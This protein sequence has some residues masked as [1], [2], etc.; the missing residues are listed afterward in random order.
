M[1]IIVDSQNVVNSAE[2]APD[3]LRAE[4]GTYYSDAQ[5]VPGTPTQRQ[6][7]G[8]FASYRFR[9]KQSFIHEL[10]VQSQQLI[11]TKSSRVF[12]SGFKESFRDQ[13]Q[14][15]EFIESI[16]PLGGQNLDHQFYLD[17]VE[18]NNSFVK[19]Y[20]HPQ[21][22]DET[23]SFQSNQLINYNLVSYP[24]KEQK[25]NV[26][27]IADI[28]TPYD[29]ETYLVNNSSSLRDLMS[30]FRNRMTS[31][32]GNTSEIADK[33]RNIFRLT[34]GSLIS[35]EQYPYH[36][37]KRMTSFLATGQN[38]SIN[39][40]K[41]DLLMARYGK[42]K[43]L[44]QSIKTGLFSSQRQF[45]IGPG[46]V[47]ATIHN[48][49]GMMTSNRI[50]S[51]QEGADEL[52]LLPQNQIDDGTMQNRFVDQV[53]TVKF[54][55]EM[56]TFI[57][58]NSRTYEEIVK[59]NSSESF[60]VGYK[61]E[62]YLDNDATSP[63]QTYYTTKPR[64]YDTQ[65]KYGRKYIYK[66]KI[67][68]GVLGSSYVYSNL[69]IS[70]NSVAMETSGREL[71]GQLPAGYNDISSEEYRAYVDVEV[72]PSFQVVEYEVDVDEVAFMDTPTLPPQVEFFNQGHKASLE[73]FFS[74]IFARVESVTSQSP[75]EVI[76]EL[77]PLTEEE[78]RIANLVSISKDT[79]VRPEYF[80]GI[81]EIYRLSHPPQTQEDFADARVALVDDKTSLI[82]PTDT[83][84]LA[85]RVFDNKNGHYEDR[86]RTN[87]KYY[88]A[89]RAVTYHG[90]PSNLTLPY[91]VE[92]L[93]DSDEF[94]VSVAEY[95]YP[96]NSVFTNAKMAKRIMKV[97]PNLERLF[98]TNNDKNSYKLDNGNMIEK[99]Q[100]TRFK[101]RITSKHTGKKID[102]N[103]NLILNE[104]SNTFS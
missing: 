49:I 8:S 58:N 36:Y 85:P 86:I 25:E 102:I 100:V 82:Y 52:F 71:I 41:F 73:F 55:A 81:Y 11:P 44:L 31:Y 64:L 63:I 69:A 40:N 7:N 92:L 50:I 47:S 37:S 90:T 56:R 72:S 20:H 94:K 6:Q 59:S 54:L 27:N 68:I 101:I 23:K 48:F 9:I 1:P 88:Y 18:V 45:N 62:K 99:G 21:Y 16:I 67:L 42:T 80:T 65:L 46:S 98:F 13:I 53:N 4:I 104:D 78:Q 28:R 32:S 22:E 89:F 19:N 95:H 76:R 35:K 61:I 51:V 60:F 83:M 24:F 57:G 103:L 30:E 79:S 34:E 14:W 2:T 74:P 33:Q 15:R 3:K 77:V 29:N 10:E 43:S 70:R 26:R 12:I 38:N 5:R 66:T 75:N 96:S 93:R 91:E 84:G 87:Q 17:N 97:T 39:P